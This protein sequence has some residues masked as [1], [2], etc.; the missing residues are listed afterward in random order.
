MQLLALK[1]NA[2]LNVHK[3]DVQTDIVEDLF[4]EGLIDVGL[5][6]GHFGTLSAARQF[7]KSVI[8]YEM[9][10][11]CALVPMPAKTIFTSLIMTN[12]DPRILILTLLSIVCAA[13]LWQIYFIRN[14]NKQQADSA[15]RFIFGVY[16][17]FITQSLKFHKNTIIQMIILQ[18]FIF[19]SILLGIVYQ[20]E[21][22]SLLANPRHG[23]RIKSVEELM[24]LDYDFYAN[25]FFNAVMS[26]LNPHEEF[27]NKIKFF[28]YWLPTIA[29]P[30]QF[31]QL[32]TAKP[33]NVYTYYEQILLG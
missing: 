12:F 23:T 28:D 30:A 1:Q 20:S 11:Y 26:D 7:L 17:V 4:A 15:L 6:T 8:S 13:I 29:Y 3:F 2:E 14:V 24:K 9:S 16:A 31:R 18:I 5:N 25:R 33:K 19:A 22:A 21:V 10:G 27:L 32:M